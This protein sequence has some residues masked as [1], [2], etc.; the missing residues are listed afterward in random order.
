VFLINRGEIEGRLN[1]FF[2]APHFY[3][4]VKEIMAGKNKVIKLKFLASKITDGTHFTPQ[5]KESGVK[6]LSVKDV[7]EHEINFSKTKFIS[8]EEHQQLNKRCN[9]ESGDILLTKVG[10]IGLAAVIPNNAPNFSIFVSV[11]LIKLKNR[12]INPHYLAVF[13]NTQLARFQEQRILKGVGVP[14]F[15]LEDIGNL[16]IP[17]PDLNRQQQIAD[18]LLNAH[19]SKKSKEA[20]A[21]ALLASIDGYLLQELGITLPL[22]SKKKTFFI[23]RS[24]QLSGGRFDPFYH[25]VEFDSFEKNLANGKYNIQILKSLVFKVE[26]GKGMYEFNSAGFDYLNVNNIKRW[27]VDLLKTEK[28]ENIE[29]HLNTVEKGDILT[30]R[31][32]TIGNFAL[33]D[34]EKEALISDNV[35]KLRA[36]DG[37]SSAYLTCVLN[38]NIIFQQLKR[39]SKGA[40]QEVINTQTIRNLKIP[41][42]PIEK[43]TEIANHISAIRFSAKQLQQQAAFELEQAKQQVE[44]LI[45]GEIE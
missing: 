14:D 31:V 20:E 40:V 41:L 39:N 37:I 17:L 29:Y 35:L 19:E 2:Y 24:S 22:D 11:A 36:K 16:L 15:H 25:L 5:Y 13:L 45:L 26:T 1:P 33:Y 21:A 30:G 43:Q 18:F 28:I 3:S 8:E 32:G 42:P 34:F 10:T 38:S 12:N 9:P 23:T 27:E 4:K 44:K 6:F 7:R